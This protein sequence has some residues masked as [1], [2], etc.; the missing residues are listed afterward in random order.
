MACHCSSASLH[1]D[2]YNYHCL[3]HYRYRHHNHY[4]SNS[5]GNINTID[6]RYIV[7]IY[8]TI[9]HITQQL[10]WWN[11]GDICTNERHP[12]PRPNGRAMG[13]LS[14]D[15][16]RKMTAIYR[17]CTV[18]EIKTPPPH[19][20]R[21]FLQAILIRNFQDFDGC[22]LLLAKEI[23]LI[24]NAHIFCDWPRVALGL[25]PEAKSRTW[26][27]TPFRGERKVCVK[28][29]LANSN[30]KVEWRHIALGW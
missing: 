22:T 24:L 23:Q 18:V 30:V 20:I 10:Q 17:E 27:S 26:E 12:I 11:F 3:N 29:V 21:V 28:Y 19:N 2:R 16:R 5:N 9:V 14:W 15:K 13:C 4:Q 1:H 7:G 8:N 6:P 25:E